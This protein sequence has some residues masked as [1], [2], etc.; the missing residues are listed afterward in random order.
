MSRH[1]CTFNG[2][3]T[4]A[5]P[6]RKSFNMEPDQNHSRPIGKHLTPVNPPERLVFYPVAVVAGLFVLTILMTVA[7]AFGDP[8]AP[9]NH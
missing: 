6:D 7:S 5:E 2:S 9:V 3:E 1:A 4:P 8:D